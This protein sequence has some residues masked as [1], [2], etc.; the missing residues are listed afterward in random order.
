MAR[1][2]KKRGRNKPERRAGTKPQKPESATIFGGRSGLQ[3]T[4]VVC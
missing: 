3:R 2:W 4:W 1:N